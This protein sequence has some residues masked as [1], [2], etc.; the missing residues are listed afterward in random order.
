LLAENWPAKTPSPFRQVVLAAPDVDDTVFVN[1]IPTIKR[2]LVQHITAYMSST[3]IAMTASHFWRLT[4]Y[5]VGD[6]SPEPLVLPEMDS[7]DV[8]NAIS[9]WIGHD[10][11]TTNRSVLADL[12]EL[13]SYGKS[14][15]RFAVKEA[16]TTSMPK[17]KY[18][19]F[20]P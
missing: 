7:V 5:R 15:P 12:A 8:S 2:R 16:F 9:D 19:I 3:D 18:W 1:A 10:Y 17:R 6:S 20:D 13:L 11:I 14:P 4:S